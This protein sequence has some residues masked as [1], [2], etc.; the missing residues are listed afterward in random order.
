[1]KLKHLSMLLALG[2]AAVF[3]AGC[4]SVQK[5]SGG[6]LNGQSLTAAGT[7]VAHINVSNTG[8]YFLKYPLITGSSSAPGSVSFFDENSVKVEEATNM[9]TKESAASGATK[10]VDIVSTAS[11]AMVPIPIPFLFFFRTVNVSGNAIK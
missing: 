2:A 9:L 4:S 3:A 10:T 11:S 5:V 1:M 7:S 6:D 8:F